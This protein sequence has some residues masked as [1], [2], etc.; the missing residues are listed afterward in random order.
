MVPVVSELRLL[1]VRFDPMTARLA[2]TDVVVPLHVYVKPGRYVR[3]TV[4]DSGRGMEPTIQERIF[5]P[6]FTTKG[7][8]RGRGLGLA[9]VEG[10]VDSCGGHSVKGRWDQISRHSLGWA[11]V[12]TSGGD[13]CRLRQRRLGWR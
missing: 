7:L 11:T 2:R 6:F 12:R 9:V 13:A 10:I 5:D 1:S 3:I 8:G 4:S